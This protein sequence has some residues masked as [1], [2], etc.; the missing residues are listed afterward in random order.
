MQNSVSALGVQKETATKHF[1]SEQRTD[2]CSETDI[3]SIRW[4]IRVYVP[5][6]S[7]IWFLHFTDL[8]SLIIKRLPG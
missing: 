7:D 4:D 3:G 2:S 6:K 5:Y 8:I 1:M